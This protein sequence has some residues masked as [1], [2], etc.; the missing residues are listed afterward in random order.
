MQAFPF[1]QFAMASRPQPC[2]WVAWLKVVIAAE[3]GRADIEIKDKSAL[4][5]GL[6]KVGERH[7]VWM[8]HGDRVTTIA[9]GLHRQGHLGERALCRRHG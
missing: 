4:F 2:N 5:D 6:W 1:C 7:P 3:F 8:S 9:C